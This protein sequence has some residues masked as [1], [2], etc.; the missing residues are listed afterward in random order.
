MRTSAIFQFWEVGYHFETALEVACENVEKG[1]NVKFYTGGRYLQFS[2]HKQ[3]VKLSNRFPNQSPL[4]R[5]KT[6]IYSKYLPTKFEFIDDWIMTN[7]RAERFAE[8]AKLSPEDLLCLTYDKFEIG[9]STLASLTNIL[10]TDP[11]LIPYDRLEHQIRTIVSSGVS[12]YE[13]A[14]KEFSESRPDNVIVFN[15]RFVHDAAVTAAAERLNIPVYFHERGCDEHR[16]SLRPFRPHNFELLVAEAQSLW[17]SEISEESAKIEVAEKWFD[18]RISTGLGGG[19]VS[20]SAHFNRSK[21]LGLMDELGIQPNQYVLFATTS[22]DEFAFVHS[23]IRRNFGWKD[24]FSLVKDLANLLNNDDR[25][26][27]VRLHPNLTTKDKR[28]R[29][30]WERLA[31]SLPNSIFVAPETDVDSYTLAKYSDSIVSVG[32]TLGLEALYMGKKTICCAQSLYSEINGCVLV[33]TVR[34][35]NEALTIRESSE[36]CRLSVLKLGYFFATCGNS[37]RFFKP[38]SPFG[39]TLFGQDIFGETFCCKPVL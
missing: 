21:D 18:G 1:G 23:S 12:V 16:Y 25:K 30:E 34:E 10:R 32:S 28:L 2:E 31:H 7:E 8:I 22:D 36:I 15:G 19:W 24:Q 3:V 29:M 14:I 17:S 13:S 35:L 11:Y 37:F 39:G 38:S 5:T 20:Y 26:L 27:V 9:S 4:N 6:L 33:N